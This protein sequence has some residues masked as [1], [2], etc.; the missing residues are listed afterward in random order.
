[1]INLAKNIMA[2]LMAFKLSMIK[3][4][5]FIPKLSL[6][7]HYIFVFLLLNIALPGRVLCDSSGRKRAESIY[8]L[9]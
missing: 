8:N 2:H 6:L 1:M 4:N 7:L 5:H 9:K 3:M